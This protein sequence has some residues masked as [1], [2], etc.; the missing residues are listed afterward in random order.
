MRVAEEGL[1]RYPRA[2]TLLLSAGEI[3]AQAGDMVKGL[4]YFARAALLDPALPLPFISAARV[5]QQLGQFQR[6]HLHLQAA[7]R[8][9]DSL[10]M[11]YVDLSQLQRQQGDTTAAIATISRALRCAKQVSEI[12]D[13]LSTKYLARLQ[14]QCGELGLLPAIPPALHNEVEVDEGKK[15]E[16]T[17]LS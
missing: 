4:Q 16:A 11:T 2:S 3:H 10:A 5:Y 7:L 9:D 14:Q 6:A 13:V 17:P 15:S 1:S 12:R 8:L